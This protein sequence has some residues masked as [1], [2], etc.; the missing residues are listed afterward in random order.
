WL[1]YHHDGEEGFFTAPA[2]PDFIVD[3]SPGMKLLD[4]Y[5]STALI[6]SRHPL[7]VFR[8]RIERFR[9]LSALGGG[10]GRWRDKDGGTCGRDRGEGGSGSDNDRGEGG[11]KANSSG[12]GN[13]GNSLLD[14]NGRSGSK[15]NTGC[16]ESG[17][18]G[19]YIHSDIRSAD[20]GAAVPFI[21]SRSLDRHIGRRVRIAGFMVTEKEIRTRA[22]QEM[23]FV[24]FEDAYGI[25]ETVVFPQVYRRLALLLEEGVAFILDGIVEI[26]WGALQLQVRNL[27][28]LNRRD[29]SILHSGVPNFH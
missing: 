6:L 8:S 10:N 27:T 25:F 23:S 2:V 12:S 18:S 3:Y 22:R 28:P 19:S 4:E 29:R 9:E 1:Y 13:A 21:D 17:E 20:T 15:A 26:E 24:S 5:R 7:E 16:K 14:I 11:S